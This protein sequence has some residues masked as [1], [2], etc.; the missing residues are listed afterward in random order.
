MDR[1]LA[2]VAINGCSITL[3]CSFVPLSRQESGP[4]SGFPPPP[5]RRGAPEHH[6]LMY[7]YDIQEETVTEELRYRTLLQPKR[8]ASR[9]VSVLVHGAIT[10]SKC[11]CQSADVVPFCLEDLLRRPGAALAELMH[12]VL[13]HPS[14]QVPVGPRLR[15][16]ALLLC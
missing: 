15:A 4:I 8:R 7:M 3:T 12:R 10:A 14:T 6:P 11:R 1:Y 16:S 13:R 9:S 5:L 2:A